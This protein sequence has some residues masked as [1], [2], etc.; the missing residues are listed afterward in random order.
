MIPA[1]SVAAYR[2]DS[3]VVEMDLEPDPPNVRHDQDE[4]VHGACPAVCGFQ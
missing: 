4:H 2:D 1:V 3:A